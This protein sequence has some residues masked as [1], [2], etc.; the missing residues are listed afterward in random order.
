MLLS[1]LPFLSDGQTPVISFSRWLHSGRKYFGPKQN[2][3]KE[4][5]L[6][7]GWFC[8]MNLLLQCTCVTRV[9]ATHAFPS[10]M[11]EWG[12]CYMARCCFSCAFSGENGCLSH[13]TQ[14]YESHQASS[15][16][17]V[18][19]LESVSIFLDGLTVGPCDLVYTCINVFSFHIFSLCFCALFAGYL[20]CLCLSTAVWLK[21]HVSLWLSQAIF[22]YV[23][24]H[25]FHREKEV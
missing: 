13:P 4:E 25:P 6:S 11:T 14:E 19:L 16:H 22:M 18:V 10:R 24:T 1:M 15:L 5:Q 21:F 3:S 12:A 8:V 2:W 17:C 23:F 7:V 9:Y 20:V